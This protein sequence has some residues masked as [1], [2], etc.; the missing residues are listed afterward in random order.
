MDAIFIEGHTR[1][2]IFSHLL[3]D[4]VHYFHIP[5]DVL[6]L[7]TYAAAIL[8]FLF[9]CK[10]LAARMFPSRLACWSATLLAGICFTIP[11]AAT[12]LLLMDPYVTARSFSTPLSLLA[13]V[14]CVDRSWKQVCL[15][16]VLVFILHPLMAIYLVCFLLTAVLVDRSQWWAALGLCAAGFLLCA[17]L[18][19]STRHASITTAYREAAL[20][21]S[22]YFL[23]RWQWY[24][25]TGLVAPLI[26]MT[27]TAIGSG[28]RSKIGKL[29]ATCV[30]VGGTSCLSALCFVH[31]SHPD[32][33]MR[34]QILRSI[35]IIYGIGV[36]MLGGFIASHFARRRIWIVALC[37]ALALLG[38]SVGDH[39]SYPSSPH[40]EWPWELSTNPREQA[41]LWIRANTPR[42]AVFAVDPSTFHDSDADNH[43][44]RALSERSTLTDNK[45]EGVASLFPG[46]A[47]TWM[48]R[49]DAEKDLDQLDDVSRIKRLSPYGVTWLLLSSHAST[50]FACPF[51]NTAVAVCRMN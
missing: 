46:L 19:F 8:V 17:L 29:C 1:L 30:L 10:Q 15:W 9:A 13:V 38:M 2:S 42:N 37:F 6:L 20:S 34:L 26:L 51:R 47:T 43:G 33:L 39:Q 5:L 14:A 23:S 7:S 12:S 36:V 32:L 11:V 18:Y 49:R 45:D 41:F 35:H 3:A 28:L 50:S 40:I 44:F 31:T 24:E 22:Y 25:I 21:R 16:V 27:A 4:I 48:Q